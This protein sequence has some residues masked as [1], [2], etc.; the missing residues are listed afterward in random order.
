MDKNN[1]AWVV[2]GGT[3]G[4]PAGHFFS[5]ALEIVY[6]HD[7]TPWERFSELETIV[8]HADSTHKAQ[9]R[10]GL[11]ETVKTIEQV[12]SG[13]ISRDRAFEVLTYSLDNLSITLQLA[14]PELSEAIKEYENQ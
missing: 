1:V 9:L 2:S 3:E 13:E 7:L 10:D 5:A 11:P 6:G 8:A 4:Y 14:L 12:F